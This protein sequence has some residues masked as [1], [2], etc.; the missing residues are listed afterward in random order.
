MQLHTLKFLFKTYKE[1]TL[2]GRYI[3][4]ESIASLL[5]KMGNS[6]RV[7]I[8]GRSVNKLPIHTVTLGVGPKKIL[9]WSQMHGN[10]ST[11]TKAV[12]DMLNAFSDNKSGLDSILESCTIMIVPILNPDGAEVYTR[13][14]AN[15]VDL[16]RDAQ[17]LSQPESRVL[18]QLF[19]KFR[20]DYCYN[21]HGQR[22]IYNVENTKRTATVSF[23]APAQD[24]ER[25]VTSTRKI[26]MEIISVMNVNL[27]EQIEGHVGIYDDGFN[28]NCVGDTF[29]AHNVPTMLFEAGHY[30]NDYDREVTRE[31]VFQSLL[32]SLSYIAS[33]NI[34]GSGYLPYLNIPR[35]AKQFF[36]IIIENTVKGNVAIQY[37][38]KLVD[39]ILKFIPKIEKMGDLSGF[40]AHRS[41][42]ANGHGVFREDGT[43]VSVGDENDFVVI[44]NEKFV[45]KL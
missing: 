28:L 33:Q 12:F 1:D 7:E 18:R 40:Y 34:D 39:G 16:N 37:Q 2:F 17:D 32:V 22:T 38:E 43:A 11:T 10:E 41:I 19:D 31:F 4:Q 25:S 15:A 8:A 21:L 26:A 3:H 29:Q 30:P 42:N 24:E 45:L 6:F 5:E 44:N 27:Q 20:P 35:N 36:D 9:M 14:N 13:L 23:L